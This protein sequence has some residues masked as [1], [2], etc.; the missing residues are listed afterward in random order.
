MGKLFAYSGTTT[1]IRAMKSRL[2]T[3]SDYRD[4]SAMK[5]VTDALVYLKKKPGY[6]KLFA[7]RDERTLHRNE[8]EI[9]LIKSVYADFRKLYRFSSADQRKFLDVYF[10]RYETAM[11]KSCMRRLFDHQSIT[12][13]TGS[14]REFFEKH[15]ALDLEKLSTSRTLEEFVENLNGSR[16]YAP[17]KR[18]LALPSPTLWDFG[19]AL[20][21]F[22][23]Q[24]MWEQKDSVLKDKES[25]AFFMD[26][27]GAKIDLL[28]LQWI[29]RSR[30]Y[31]QMPPAQIYAMVIPVQYRLKK[32]DIQALAEAGTPEAFRQALARTWYGRHFDA[33]TPETLS[34]AYMQ[35]RHRIQ[36]DNARKEPYSVATVISY[37]F[38]KEHE[39]DRLTTALEGI[40]YGLAPE[41]IQNY[42]LVPEKTQRRYRS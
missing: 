5:T 1:K 6:D 26:A 31:F 17:L 24:W 41:E 18:V 4:L 30:K 37:L 36:T 39:I 15:S 34:Q 21:L 2:L 19:M 33:L 23:F 32:E 35:I 9:I 16:Y 27:Y 25:Q 28:N 7:N 29:Y 13:Y 20:D 40:R 42:V 12:F 22:Y 10:G 8:I 38:E 14:F 11:L 3:D